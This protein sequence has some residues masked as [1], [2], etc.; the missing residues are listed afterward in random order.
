MRMYIFT[1]SKQ[2]STTEKLITAIEESTIKRS[3][4]H[5]EA[6]ARQDKLLDILE[7]MLDK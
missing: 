2:F 5:D 7:K 6:M 1:G 3:K 4:M